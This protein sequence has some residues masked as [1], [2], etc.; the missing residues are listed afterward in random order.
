MNTAGVRTYIDMEPEVLEQAESILSKIG[1]TFSQAVKLFTKQIVLRRSF[2]VE[3]NVPI[4]Q[5]LCLDDMTDEEVISAFDKGMNNI[6]AGKYYTSE[7]MRER[8]EKR[9]GIAF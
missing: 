8:A 4:E 7:E 5:P 3:L 9:Y 6:K 1:M 2:P